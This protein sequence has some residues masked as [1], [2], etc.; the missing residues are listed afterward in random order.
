[1]VV[2][3]PR[4]L[5]FHRLPGAPVFTLDDGPPVTL[6]DLLDAN[7]D[8]DDLPSILGGMD[9]GS[10]ITLGGGAAGEIRIR[11]LSYRRS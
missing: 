11:R 6:I 2:R 8:D 4:P 3:Y 9:E 1:M 7:P 10:E 5:T